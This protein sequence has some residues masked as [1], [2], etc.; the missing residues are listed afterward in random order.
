[1]QKQNYEKLYGIFG[2]NV[3]NFS[4]SN[5]VTKIKTKD[6][7]YFKKALFKYLQNSAIRQS[8]SMI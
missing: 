5:A 1:M 4:L 2:A 8:Q 3:T 6:A 7:H